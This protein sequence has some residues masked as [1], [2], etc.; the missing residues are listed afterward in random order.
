MYTTAAILKKAKELDK[1]NKKFF[2][3][4]KKAKIRNMDE[5]FQEAHE[6]A[7]ESID[8]LTCANCCKT[9]SPIFK[10]RDIDRIAPLFNLKSQAFI[11]KYLHLDDENDYVLNSAPCPFLE[12]DNKCQIYEHR[13]DACSEYPHTNSRKMHTLLDLTYRNT[14][15]CPAVQDIV[16]NLANQLNNKI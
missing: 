5:L 1:S 16:E 15:V 6:Q 14:F 12:N 9:T 2:Q 3:K 4:L 11:D 7:F 13:P 10:N 8:C